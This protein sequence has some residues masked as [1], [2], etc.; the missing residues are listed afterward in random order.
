MRFTIQPL[1]T[2]AVAHATGTSPLTAGQAEFKFTAVV[3]D[4]AAVHD[5]RVTYAW[6][7]PA[8]AP[9]RLSQ[10]FGGPTHSDFHSCFAIDLAEGTPVL[11][12][13]AGVVVFL[14][15]RYFESGLNMAKFRQKSNQIRILH[16][17]GSMASYGHLFPDSIDLEPGQRVELGQQIG[18]SGNTGYS[19]GP[20]LHFVLM[21]MR[22]MRMVSIP[23]RMQGK[24]LPGNPG[25]PVSCQS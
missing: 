18:L 15:D 24:N 6:P 7:F 19:S 2:H 8:G 14:E 1:E 10:G 9:A 3:G 21:V 16:A 25:V 20:H 5:D 11:A 4:P 17:D 23:F 22:D 12:S 13:R